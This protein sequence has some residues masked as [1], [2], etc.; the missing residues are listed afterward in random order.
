MPVNLPVPPATEAT[1]SD[2]IM[3]KYVRYITAAAAAAPGDG[4]LKG[5]RYEI[6]AVVHLNTLNKL[7]NP[8][9]IS[10]WIRQGE[11][12]QSIN[13]GV[14]TE[15][16][17]AVN[18]NLYNNL[19]AAGVPA[20]AG[21]LLGD[22]KNIQGTYGPAVKSLAAY[23]MSNPAQSAGICFIGTRGQGIIWYQMI[24]SLYQML[25][26]PALTPGI[27]GNPWHQRA[28][29]PGRPAGAAIV[30][31]FAQYNTPAL[32]TARAQQTVQVINTE[33]ANQ[34]GMYAVCYSVPSQQSHDA[35]RDW[36]GGLNL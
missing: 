4:R 30:A 35:F 19:V 23:A 10:R 29:S 22:A 21:V 34:A 32:I 9:Q 20:L 31:H 18:A 24:T 36:F 33:L 25:A 28:A 14:N 3:T 6:N 27:G 15:F 16:D 12:N 1:V 2:R 13:C 8:N 5:E 26:N 7:T 11:A 17:F